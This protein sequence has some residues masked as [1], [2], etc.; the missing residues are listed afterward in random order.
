MLITNKAT[1][2]IT[3]QINVSNGTAHKDKQL[4][5]LPKRAMEIFS[6]EY[7]RPLT[8][9]TAQISI[10]VKRMTHHPPPKQ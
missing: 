2:M 7:G 5:A 3:F 1:G 8:I 9:S 6:P 10:I 4:V